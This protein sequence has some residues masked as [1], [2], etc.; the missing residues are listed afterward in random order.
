MEFDPVTYEVTESG[1]VVF[2]IVLRTQSQRQVTVFFATNEGSATCK[3]E[4]I[5]ITIQV[6]SL[7]GL[8][9]IYSTGGLRNQDRCAGVLCTRPAAAD[10]AGE[11]CE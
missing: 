7:H 3:C 11:H 4:A 6:I 10:C 9:T 5:N 2:M 1:S 8:V